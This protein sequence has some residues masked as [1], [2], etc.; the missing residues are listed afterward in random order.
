MNL[1]L[2]VVLAALAAS[3]LPAGSVQ[4]HAA[5]RKAA[6]IRAAFPD[7]PFTKDD[8]HTCS[9][10]ARAKEYMDAQFASRG[11]TYEFIV[12]PVVT[13]ERNL[14]YYASDG[15]S[16]R[17]VMMYKAVI[18]ACRES[19]AAVDFSGTD[20][21]GDGTA[22]GI[23]VIAAA[24]NQADSGTAA[25]DNA[26]WPCQDRLGDHAMQIRL[27]GTVIDSFAICTQDDG[28]GT[29]CHEFAH[30]FGLPD[31]Y[32]TD[33][34]GSGGLSRGL[35]KTLSL[36]DRGRH[37]CGGTTPPNFSAV[38]MDF[39]GLGSA[40]D[41][42]EPGSYA[43]QP[44]SRKQEYMRCSGGNGETILFEC[45]DRNGWDE[46]SGGAGMVIY[47]VDRSTCSAGYSDWFKRTLTALERWD[48]NQVN[49]RRDSPCASV[50]EAYPGGAD[51]MEEIFFPQKSSGVSSFT[52]ANGFYFYSTR[53]PQLALKDITLNTD[54]SVAFNVIRPIT[55]TSTDIYQDA[56]LICW[57]VHESLEPV[58]ECGI[59]W[60]QD[61][62]KL[63][64]SRTA[65]GYATIEHLEPGKNYI[66][67]VRVIAADGTQYDALTSFRTNVVRSGVPAY[68][69]LTPAERD[70]RGSF[71]KG[72]RIPLRVINAPDAA[73]VV[74]TLDGKAVSP[75]DS[76][77]YTVNEAGELRAE[78]F[79]EDGRKEVIV[80][81][82]RLQ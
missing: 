44:L 36:M 14:S 54:G 29:F 42:T 58:R 46:G 52:S 33:G 63:Q 34:D 27:D 76:G 47:H 74:W 4:M 23:I 3:L 55:F 7:S 30:L 9:M 81:E 65:D 6:V 43:L 25:P 21:D 66:A 69:C 50:V 35:W 10:L 19:D 75:D 51:R 80:K 40:V 53:A 67:Q 64:Q 20:W 22:D 16:G 59:A 17:D 48:A 32:D 15:A 41:L 38:E 72:T 71:R 13:L 28:V 78:V 49:C 11:I 24:M 57:T 39:L 70:S 56:A 5:T 68:I 82:I 2:T 18:E 26:I 73:S 60:W 45:R 1:K 37:N 12:P 31:L 61:G 62:E 8:G 77:W 79:H